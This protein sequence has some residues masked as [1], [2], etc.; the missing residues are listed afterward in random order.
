[1]I[2]IFTKILYKKPASINH[3]L[4]TPTNYFIS[5]KRELL[6]FRQRVI[7]NQPIF[8]GGWR[9]SIYISAT[10]GFLR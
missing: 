8:Q 6:Y 2:P 5:H 10:V 4:I 3:V 7:K 1:M 9:N